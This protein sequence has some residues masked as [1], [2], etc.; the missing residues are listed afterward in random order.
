MIIKHHYIPDLQSVL[1]CIQPVEDKLL[2]HKKGGAFNPANSLACAELLR[3]KINVFV[4]KPLQVE[5]CFAWDW[6]PN[7]TMQPHIDRDGLD[8]TITMPLS[9]ESAEWSIW[10]EGYGPI[11]VPYG[12]GFLLNGRKISHWRNLCPTANST[13]IMYH[14][15]EV[16]QQIEIHRQLLSQ[17]EIMTLLNNKHAWVEGTTLNNGVTEHHYRKSEVCWL[18]REQYAWLYERIDNRMHNIRDDLDRDYYEQLQ[19]TRYDEGGYFNIHSDNGDTPRKLSSTILLQNAKQGGDLT[20]EN[21]PSI[22]LNS[23]DAIF[24]DA[25]INH[26]V[27][28][29]IKGTRY[30]LVRWLN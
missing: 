19:L 10:A 16:P 20:F 25:N 2:Q 5:N 14:Y 3:P 28:P 23:G 22:H 1:E 13:W 29:V 30:S 11:T 4:T 12:A 17:A 24:F 26:E 27:K 15:R 21:V 7:G 8:W 18:D 6:K 9:K